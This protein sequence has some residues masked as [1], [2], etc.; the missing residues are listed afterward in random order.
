MFQCTGAKQAFITHKNSFR[1]HDP[2]IQ[3]SAS[4]KCR[5][6]ERVALQTLVMFNQ[7]RVFYHHPERFHSY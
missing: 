5:C 1:W 4:Y 7:F 2:V 3:D 6:R